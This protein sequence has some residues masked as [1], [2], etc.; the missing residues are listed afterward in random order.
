MACPLTQNLIL[1]CQDQVGGIETVYIAERANR[2]DTMIYNGSGQITTGILQET[3]FF[4]RYQFKK[5]SSEYKQTVQRDIVAGTTFWQTEL[6]L[7]I[8]KREF[9][10]RN[11][12]K[13]LAYNTCMIVIKDRN[14]KYWLMGENNGAEV[15]SGGDGSGKAMGDVNGYDLVFQSEEN[16]PMRELE[17]AFVNLAISGFLAAEVAPIV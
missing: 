11:E 4:Y 13:L 10:K 1:D 8:P 3:F 14:G 2:T 16:E 6:T 5:A 17:P 15:V 12:L 9:A 7:Q